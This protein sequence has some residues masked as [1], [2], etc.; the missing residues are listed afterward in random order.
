[1]KKYQFVYPAIF[2]R[3]EDGSYQVVFPDLDIYISGK[4]LTEAFLYAKN[5]LKVYFSYA[6]KYETEYNKPTQLE[7]LLAKC[8]ENETV[9]YVDTYLGVKE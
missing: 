5:L 1:M 8:K 4:N 3:D 2:I 7:K 6:L 9:M